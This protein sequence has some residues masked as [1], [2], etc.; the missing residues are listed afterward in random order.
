[1]KKLLTIALV[2]G[3]ALAGSMSSNL[4]FADGCESESQNTVPR[5]P[6]PP[7]STGN[8]TGTAPSASQGTTPTPEH[9]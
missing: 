4:A 5:D 8:D 7:A 1:M 6:P 9:T 3:I 2:T